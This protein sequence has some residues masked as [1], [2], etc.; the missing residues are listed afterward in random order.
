[1]TPNIRTPV[2]LLALSVAG[3]PCVSTAG[4]QGTSE[5]TEHGAI[6]LSALYVR[7]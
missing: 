7:R 3:L 4:V 2:P 6:A 5:G 1:M